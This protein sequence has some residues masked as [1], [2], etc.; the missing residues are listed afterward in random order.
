MCSGAAGSIVDMNTRKQNP[1]RAGVWWAALA[2]CAPLGAA[3]V[4]CSG[5]KADSESA[6]LG[7]QR[8]EDAAIKHARCMREQGVDVPDPKPGQ[9]GVVL[10]GPR[11][12]G[13]DVTAMEDAAKACDRYLKGVAQQ[14]IS[15]EEK[16]E[17][18]DAALKHARCMR[19][20]GIDFP[21]PQVDEDGGIVVRI[22]EGFGPNDPA[23]RRA[24]KACAKYGPGPGP[25]PDS[26]EVAP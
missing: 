7:Q 16:N 21:D 14:S 4:G 15:D 8:F 17:M 11:G 13:G 12:A 6:A 10:R 23:V 26:T 2:I 1:R 5:E 25:M 22:G 19:D 9:G 3:F 20:E 18:R 24:E